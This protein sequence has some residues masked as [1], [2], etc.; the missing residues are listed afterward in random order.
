M[1]RAL[2]KTTGRTGGFLGASLAARSS[3]RQYVIVAWGLVGGA[4]WLVGSLPGSPASGWRLV[5]GLYLLAVLAAICAID[6]RYGIIPNSLVAALAV[7]GLLQTFLPG[8]GEALQR[9]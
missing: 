2:R 3:D 9:G 4:I 1:I 6:A 8:Q 7:G 5:A